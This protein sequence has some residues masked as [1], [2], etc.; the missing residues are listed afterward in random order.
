MKKKICHTIFVEIP[1]DNLREEAVAYMNDSFEHANI[2]PDIWPSDEELESRFNRNIQDPDFIR[3]VQYRALTTI[4]E[5]ILNI[6]E[7]HYEGEY[8]GDL[9]EKSVDLFDEEQ[10]Q[11]DALKHKHLESAKAKLAEI[12]LTLEERVALGLKI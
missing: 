5:N 6:F 8:I 12:K 11:R 3:H 2:H 7:D 4:S 1:V 9:V 10:R